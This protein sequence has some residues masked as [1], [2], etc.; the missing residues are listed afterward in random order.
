[1]LEPI[2]DF[3]Q[4]NVHIAPYFI[5]ALLLLAGLNLPVSEDLMLFVSGVLASQYP[6]YT[7]P[8]FLGVFIG[9]YASDL[10]CYAVFGRFLGQ[11]IFETKFFSKDRRLKRL[12][13]I[14]EFYNRYGNLTLFFGRFIPFGVRNALFISAGLSKMSAWKFATIDF[15]SCIIS[16]TSYFLLYK[17]F[18]PSIFPYVKQGKIMAISLLFILIIL[19]LIFWKRKKA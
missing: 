1:M 5:C 10:I 6:S 3:I 15:F 14:E 18:G 13:K 16:S 11:K 19:G 2:L 9:S 7:I 4:A 12:K 8:L 17:N